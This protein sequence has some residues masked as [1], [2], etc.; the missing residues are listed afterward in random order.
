MKGREERILDV[1]KIIDEHKGKIRNNPDILGKNIIRLSVLQHPDASIQEITKISNSKLVKKIDERTAFN[2]IKSYFYNS[3]NNNRTLN[4]CKRAKNLAEKLFEAMI[5][6]GGIDE[7]ETIYEKERK[8]TSNIHLAFISF[9]II[10]SDA[11]KDTTILDKIMSF[12]QTFS[13]DCIESIISYI[14]VDLSANTSDYE[15]EILRLES[16]RNRANNLISRL[17]EEFDDRLTESKKEEQEK[18]IQELNSSRYDYILD[19]LTRL[20]NGLKQMRRERIAVPIQINSLQ[21][22]VR[23]MIQFVEDCGITPIMDIGEQLEI[24]ARETESY[25]YRGNPFLGNEETKKVMVVTTGWENREK[26]IIIS[27]PAVREIEDV[28]EIDEASPANLVDEAK[29]DIEL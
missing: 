5:S 15:K 8:Y 28:N 24:T 11:I 6:D 27:Q 29:A 10:I 12:G 18:L 14:K 20:Q 13:V 1:I 9:G 4:R 3:E 26:Q 21:S 7:F 23:N 22:F 19:Q 17:Q 16:E 2:V 25:E